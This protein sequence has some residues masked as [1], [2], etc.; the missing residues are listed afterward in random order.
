MGCT[1]LL[2]NASTDDE[3]FFSTLGDERAALLPNK[4]GGP[5][6]AEAATTRPPKDGDGGPRSHSEARGS[7]AQELAAGVK[8]QLLP[9]GLYLGLTSSAEDPPLLTSRTD[10]TALGCINER[11][12]V[13]SLRGEVASR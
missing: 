7:T 3:G 2:V 8:Q 1:P 9:R 13:A 5:R 4:E 10:E 11:F 6:G 12:R